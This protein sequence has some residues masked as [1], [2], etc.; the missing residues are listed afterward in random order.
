MKE[1]FKWGTLGGSNWE[2]AFLRVGEMCNV[3]KKTPNG[4]CMIHAKLNV[5]L[6]F[7][8]VWSHIIRLANT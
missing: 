4:T 1:E 5:L 2:D 3:A 6:S 7:R 8:F